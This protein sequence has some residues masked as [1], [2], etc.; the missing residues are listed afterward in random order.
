MALKILV[1]QFQKQAA[2]PFFATGISAGFPS[3]ADDFI[4]KHLDLNDHLITNK[5]ATFYVK[6]SGDSMINAGINHGDLLIVDRSLTAKNNS[7]VVAVV[8]TEFTVKRL[9]LLKDGSALL[10]PENDKYKPIKVQGEEELS[11]WGVVTNVIHSCL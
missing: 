8:N 2:I 6:V 11:I 9:K 7:I 4:E 1:P 5:I 3:P 10:I